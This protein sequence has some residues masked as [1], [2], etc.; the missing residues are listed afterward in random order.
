METAHHQVKE[1]EANQEQ[2]FLQTPSAQGDEDDLNCL[3]W[4]NAQHQTTRFR[5]GQEKFDK[6]FG[7]CGAKGHYSNGCLRSKYVICDK[8]KQKGHLTK[9]YRR[10]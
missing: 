9:M 5:K 7:R 10:K 4:K 3:R 1:I 6:T 2:P 8:C